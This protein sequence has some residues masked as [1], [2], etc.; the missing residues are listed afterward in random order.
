MNRV[1]EGEYESRMIIWDSLSANSISDV[2][3]FVDSMFNKLQK[4]IETTNRDLTVTYSEFV[5]M[6]NEEVNYIK[7]HVADKN[8]QR[9]W[10]LLVTLMVAGVIAISI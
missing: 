6:A 8:V 7:V 2:K 5:V 9:L 3:A 1:S 4:Q 10:Y